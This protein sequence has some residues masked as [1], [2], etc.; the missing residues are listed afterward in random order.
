[1]RPRHKKLIAFRKSRVLAILGTAVLVMSGCGTPDGSSEAE[2]PIAVRPISNSS[3]VK[4]PVARYAETAA[5]QKATSAAVNILQKKCAK[6]F[7]VISTAPITSVQPTEV[8][9]DSVRRYGLINAN[10]VA[11][12]GYALPPTGDNDEKDASGWNPSALEAEVL[13]GHTAD[14]KASKLK[15]AD[16]TSLSEGGCGA[17]GFWQVWGGKKRPA[18]DSL[19]TK[20]MS[21]SWTLTLA[22]SRAQAA[23]AKWSTCMKAR[24]YDFKR[25]AD[26]GNSTSGKLPPA[27]LAMAKLDLACAVETNYNGV[28]YAVD[29]AYQE[30]QIEKHQGELAAGL[31]QHRKMME[32]V[33][34]TLQAGQ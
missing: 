21:D 14:G 5:D 3:Q 24:G 4:L 25:R 8:E 22:D 33:Q 29:T 10:E 20:I 27:S 34:K 30:Q 11:R 16:G 7:E 9:S 13:S 18:S 26:A 31:E 17:E 15:A 28:W 2:P 23:A 1:M 19:V 6:K 12:Y 32:R